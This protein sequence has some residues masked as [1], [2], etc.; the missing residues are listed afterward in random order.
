[1]ETGVAL[2]YALA[3]EIDEDALDETLDS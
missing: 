2:A 1:M 3:D